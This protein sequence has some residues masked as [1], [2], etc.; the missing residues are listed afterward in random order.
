MAKDSL[1]LGDSYVKILVAVER[2]IKKYKYLL[3][4]AV[5]AVLLYF[6]YQKV[7]ASLEDARIQESNVLFLKEDASE[8][9]M[10]K[11]K[12][13][14]INLYAIKNI[15]KLSISD[16]ESLKVD[17]TLIEVLKINKNENSEL[18]E[19]LNILKKG[20]ALLLSGDIKRANDEFSLI[21]PNSTMSDL[22]K[23]LSHYQGVKNEK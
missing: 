20:Y 3:I 13:L 21:S 16:L 19:D 10:A 6:I 1:S 4:A 23:S 15:D 22:A 12:E 11:L 17:K 14:N 5:L 7:S 2:F 9:E 8:A 18:L